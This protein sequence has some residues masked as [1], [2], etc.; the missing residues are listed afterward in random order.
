MNNVDSCLDR[1]QEVKGRQ[2]VVAVGVELENRVADVFADQFDQRACAVGRQHAANVFET[3]S[4][5][6]HR[7]RFARFT[8][9]V[10]IRVARRDGV[11]QID[12]GL[13]AHGSQVRDFIFQCVI[14]VPGIGKARQG[15]A[16]VDHALDHQARNAGGRESKSAAESAMVAEA[17]CS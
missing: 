12:H 11:D 17:A 1:F 15:D 6:L 14:V 16:V 3:D 10:F 9:V 5:G 7:R 4:I 13:H 8:G 2:T